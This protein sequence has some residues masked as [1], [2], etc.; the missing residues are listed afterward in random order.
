MQLIDQYGWL[1]P[2]FPFLSAL[3]LGLGLLSFRRGTRSL[4][5]TSAAISIAFLGISMMLSFGLFWI[6]F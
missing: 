4:R 3:V 5:W 6:K 2:V 1:I